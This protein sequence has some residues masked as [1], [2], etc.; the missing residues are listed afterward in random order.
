M[1]TNTPR[2]RQ[3][4]RILS[5]ISIVSVLTLAT[6]GSASAQAAPTPAAP[7]TLDQARSAAKAANAGDG[8]TAI[9]IPAQ[10][11]LVVVGTDGD[12]S[13]AIKRNAAGKIVVNNGAVPILG[14]KPT[15]DNTTVLEVFG[16]GGTDDISL[17]ESNG[18][19][20]SGVVSGGDGT[21]TVTIDGGPASES[22]FLAANGPGVARVGRDTPSPFF[23]DLQTTENLV[24][25]MKGGDDRFAGQNG[26]S[27]LHLT[28][29]GG[30]GNDTILGGDGDD[31]LIGGAGLDLIDGNRGND[32]A[33][34]GAGDDT[35]QW[36]PGDGS[37]IVEGQGGTDTLL[38]NGS[39]A[40]EKIDL[41]ANGS[42]VRL[43]RDIAGITMDVDDVEKV[44]VRTLGGTDTTTVNDLSGTDV[45]DVTINGAAFDGTPDQTQD[46]VIVQ[47]TAQ[48]DVVTVAPTAGGVKV[49]GVPASVTVTATDTTDTLTVTG[50]AGDDVLDASA[51]PAGVLTIALDG[52][53]DDDVLIGSAGA[54]TLRGGDGDDVLLGGPGLDVLD[55]G[56]G[57]NVLIQD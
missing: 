24:V 30:I 16:Q 18:A 2:R 4:A 56:T 46:A 32:T 5:S 54:D 34:M 53:T 23:D 10:Q 50:L 48:N 20:P 43:F 47:A 22:Y 57:S 14:T 45:T 12:D 17:D 36:D 55:G 52:G 19:L 15:V 27:F 29:D 49:T 39:N 31:V 3:V 1:P 35:F 11:T 42:R 21:D 26:V 41:S 8:I 13:I 38:F 33:L 51:V 37:D 40:N 7:V 25:N 9:Y 6:V 44:T 28:V